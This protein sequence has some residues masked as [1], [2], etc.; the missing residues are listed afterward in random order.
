MKSKEKILRDDR[1]ITL[2][3]YQLKEILIYAYKKGI[4]ATLKEGKRS[5]VSLR[6]DTILQAGIAELLLDKTFKKWMKE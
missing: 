4:K 2:T 6:E 5:F 1:E 3:R